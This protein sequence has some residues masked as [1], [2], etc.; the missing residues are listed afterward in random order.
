[1]K[2]FRTSYPSGYKGVQ[3]LPVYKKAI[4]IFTMS[5]ELVSLVSSEKS[6]LDLGRSKERIH[7]ISDHL[8]T[9]SIGL[10]PRIALVESSADPRVR[11]SS[12]R[13]LQQETGKLQRYCDQ[14]ENRDSRT[15]AI[16]KRLRQEITQFRI[17]QGKWVGRISELN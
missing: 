13:F 7:R 10:A 9:S 8:L 17:L 6:L 2:N 16:V 15:G 4:D 11:I 5:R 14:M 3:D 12:L 1:M